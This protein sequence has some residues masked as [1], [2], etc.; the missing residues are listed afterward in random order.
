[1][2]NPLRDA[3]VAISDDVIVLCE[4]YVPGFR[5]DT[6]VILTR[7]SLCEALGKRLAV[8]ACPPRTLKRDSPRNS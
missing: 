6:Q 7:I 2:P 1:M 3:L 8:E 4:D 5:S